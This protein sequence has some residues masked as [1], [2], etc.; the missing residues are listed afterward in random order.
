MTSQVGATYLKMC[1]AVLRIQ[2]YLQWL[3]SAMR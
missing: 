1:G 2:W 3:S